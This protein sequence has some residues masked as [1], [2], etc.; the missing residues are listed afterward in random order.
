MAVVLGHTFQ[1]GNP[2]HALAYSF[3]IPLFFVL[4]GYLSRPGKPDVGKLARRLLRPYLVICAATALL[5]AIRTAPSASWAAGLGLTFLW[6]SGGD[7]TALGIPGVGFAW[8]LM[9]LF[10]ARVLFAYAQDL[11]DAHGVGEPVRLLVYLAMLGLGWATSRLVVLP[12]ALE[13][14][15]VTTF[16]LYAGHLLAVFWDRLGARVRGVALVGAAL[17]WAGCLRAGIFYSIGNLF[18][19]GALPL[20]VLMSLAS[21]LCVIEACR[22]VERHSDAGSPASS[23][24]AWIGRSSLLVLCVHWIE[25][26]FVAWAQLVQGASMAHC[27]LVGAEHVLLVLLLTVLLATSLPASPPVAQRR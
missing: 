12:L 16:Y 25:S 5:S 19:V 4:S 15:L 3:H 21:S 27:L 18:H 26:N 14:A 23:A 1:F 9:A 17:A 7:V 6:A 20:G 2:L 11:F 10:V 13:Q 8:F 22:W 24:L